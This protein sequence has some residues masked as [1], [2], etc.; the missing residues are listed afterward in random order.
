MH[1]L[2]NEN[3][4]N[5]PFWALPQSLLV[6]A[7]LAGSVFT[8]W[9]VASRGILATLVFLGLGSAALMLLPIQ[10]LVIAVIS[11]YQGFPLNLL[12][13]SLFS[14]AR[15]VVHLSDLIL[16]LI[17]FRMLPRW[18]LR[19]QPGEEASVGYDSGVL[20]FLAAFLGWAFVTSVMLRAGSYD[21]F[22][23]TMASLGKV[24]LPLLLAFYIASMKTSYDRVE[25]VLKWVIA[26]GIVQ[27]AAGLVRWLPLAITSVDP[28]VAETSVRDWLAIPSHPLFGGLPT[29]TGLFGD[30]ARLGYW[31]IVVL[32]AK[33]YFIRRKKAATIWDQAQLVFVVL[34]IVATTRRGPLSALVVSVIVYL[35]V[36]KERQLSP[37]HKVFRGGAFLILATAIILVIG[38]IVPWI[39]PV[40]DIF[41]I[42]ND[43]N[44]GFAGRLRQSIALWQNFL[45]AP[46]S[47]AGWM[48]NS[49]AGNTFWAAPNY[50]FVLADLGL[51]GLVLLFSLVVITLYRSWYKMR[52]S[53]AGTVT[54]EMGLF[55]F[56]SLAGL[57][58]AMM[59]DVIL[60][61]G[62]PT[63]LLLA[64]CLGIVAR[65]EH[66]VPPT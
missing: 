17:L 46:L 25:Y 45:N 15:I 34:G 13:I 21:F 42:T 28:I 60:I 1:L 32:W 66:D 53:S 16:L 26:W 59:S 54:Y 56:V 18:L 44:Y 2:S 47:G 10:W 19:S 8:G 48:G 4:F 65:R 20:G 41:R 43:F 50:M 40:S 24:V 63:L 61:G 27:I 38:S 22:V 37:S 12:D 62:Q 30:P 7:G 64:I 51:P 11:L 55:T 5:H 36:T 33:L 35:L 3:K 52:V 14:G 9:A 31:L 49:L 23:N 29:L 57:Y 58:A 39:R 6:V